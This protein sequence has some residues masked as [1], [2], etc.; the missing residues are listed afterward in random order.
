MIKYL[1]L[2]FVVVWSDAYSQVIIIDDN[3]IYNK[4]VYKDF[5]EFKFNCPSIPFDYKIDSVCY[6]NLDV[7]TNAAN[8]LSYHLVTD[9]QNIKNLG[10][11]YGFCDGKHIYL[12]E[13][14]P[15]VT[16]RTDFE[17]VQ[18]V[19]LYSYFEQYHMIQ[20]E[21]GALNSSAV[22]KR[23][24]NINYGECSIV[25]LDVL[26]KIFETDSIL[27]QRF[28]A[29]KDKKD[30]VKDFIALYSLK[31]KLD[32]VYCRDKKMTKA[33]ADSFI[34]RRVDEV[35][36]DVYYQRLSSK[37]KLNPAFTDSKLEKV[38]Y[39]NGKLKSIGFNT[40]C[41][42]DPSDQFLYCVG[43]W[44]MNYENGQLKEE[45]VYSITS[46]TLSRKKYDKEGK[47]IAK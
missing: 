35:S 26:D 43:V 41:N 8:H 38:Y 11:I 37:F 36:D 9:K 13:T 18:F 28:N 42:F 24:I 3:V 17:L 44:K 32:G 27:L 5:E 34:L 31:H 16:E 45:A 23:I 29:Q 20:G 21:M 14:N 46:K 10:S 6:T 33:E 40:R 30:K 15:I 19:G 1:L 25:T 4:G 39:S 47:L 12:N 22:L 7:Y 2:F